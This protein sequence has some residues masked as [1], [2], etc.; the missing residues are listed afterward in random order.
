MILDYEAGQDEIRLENLASGKVADELLEG[1][2]LFSQTS[3]AETYGART[4]DDL[5]MQSLLALEGFGVTQ[6]SRGD[7]VIFDQDR[8]FKLV[9]HGVGTDEVLAS[10]I[11]FGAAEAA[12][13]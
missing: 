3:L 1:P 12:L 13:L 5:D 9:F 2:A 7:A 11:F 6:N 4:L 8:S 10:D